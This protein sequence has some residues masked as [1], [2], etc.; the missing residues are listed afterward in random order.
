[1]TFRI[2]LRPKGSVGWMGAII[3][4]Q[5]LAKAIAMHSAETNADI[6]VKIGRASCRERVCT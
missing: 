3:Y 4:T 5:N 2:C 1:M 6:T